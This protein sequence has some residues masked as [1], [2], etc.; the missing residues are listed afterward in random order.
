MAASVDPHLTKESSPG[1]EI[2]TTD[3]EHF[4]SLAL[5]HE[6]VSMG[7]TF[8]ASEHSSTRTPQRVTQS[9]HATWDKDPKGARERT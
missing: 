8:L 2:R 7:F 5:T 3:R 9:R 6:H 1:E 4:G